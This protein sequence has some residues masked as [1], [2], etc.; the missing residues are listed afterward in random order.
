[1]VSVINIV[2]NIISSKIDKDAYI[3][4]VHKLVKLLESIFER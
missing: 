1:M 4:Y 3:I 2:K